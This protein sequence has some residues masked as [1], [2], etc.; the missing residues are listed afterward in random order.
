MF[1]DK[2]C[3]ISTTTYTTVWGVKKRA[4][5]PLY[6]LIECNFEANEK[7]MSNTDY[8]NNVELPTYIVVLPVKYNQ[9]RPNQKIVLIDPVLWEVGT[10]ITGTAQAN[11]S[12]SWL[13]D[14][15]TLPVYAQKWQ[16]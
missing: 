13:I 5:T 1:F 14:C 8:A 2:K 16:L 9:I 10:Y 6:S 15:I 12:I 3:T 7:R 4:Y 11:K